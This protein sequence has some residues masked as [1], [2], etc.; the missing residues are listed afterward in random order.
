MEKI[1]TI[2]IAAYNAELDIKRCLDSF[3]S[4]NVLEELELIVVNDGSK[5][6]TAFILDDYAK[7]DARIRVFH[8]PNAG[9]A[10]ARN[11][12]LNKIEDEEW[13]SFID[14]DEDRKSVV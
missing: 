8:T 14:A 3:I 10:S 9:A 2:S 12:A 4:T 1:L 7:K 11:F 5:D 13:I 6:N